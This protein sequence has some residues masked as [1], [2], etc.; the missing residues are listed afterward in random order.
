[1]KYLRDEIIEFLINSLNTDQLI[2]LARNF[3][4][5]FDIYRESGFEQKID[6]PRKIAAQAILKFLDQEESILDFVAFVLSREGGGAGSGGIVHVRGRQKLFKA[7]HD[8]NWIYNQKYNRFEKDQSRIR[9]NDWGIL[10]ENL[11]Y[12]FAL[13]SD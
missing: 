1:M 7:L 9:T 6:I 10:R 3:N 5:R 13:T 11:T 2:N 8:Y 4:P 12:S